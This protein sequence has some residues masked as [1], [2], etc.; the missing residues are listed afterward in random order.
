MEGSSA[1]APWILAVLALVVV[2]ARGISV[3]VP[4][5]G[6]S[7][8]WTVIP[9]KDIA[10]NS[11]TLYRAVTN[12]GEVQQLPPCNTTALRAICESTP[13]CLA[14]NT[15]GYLKSTASTA[16]MVDA[17][18][19]TWV[20]AGG[21]PP[22]T[23]IHLPYEIPPQKDLHY[24]EGLRNASAQGPPSL[25]ALLQDGQAPIATWA[26]LQW[27]GSTINASVEQMVFDRWQFR[28]LAP[29]TLLSPDAPLV[30]VLEYQTD[31]WGYLAFV[32]SDPSQALVLRQTVG[33]LSDIQ[34]AVYTM[35]EMYYDLLSG[36]LTDLVATDILAKT[37]EP[38]SEEL[39]KYMTPTPDYGL[40]GTVKSTMKWTT[41]IVG[42]IKRADD[43][44][45]EFPANLSFP[46]PGSVVFDPLTHLKSRPQNYSVVKNGLFGGYY[47]V[48]MTSARNPNT[49][50]GFEQVAFAAD[51]ADRS[52]Q[53]FIRLYDMETDA[54]TYYQQ[55]GNV[56]DAPQPIPAS[57]F[58]QYLLVYHASLQATLATK[59][60]MAV[61]LPSTEL[62]QMDMAMGALVEGLTVFL[63]LLPNYGTGF[64]YWSVRV[65][66]GS[67]LPLT[68]F[69]VDNA[70]SEWGFPAL[71]EARVQYYMQTFVRPDGTIN[72]Y[73]WSQP[74]CPMPESPTGQFNDG[75]ADY[76]RLLDLY[77]TTA[78]LSQNMDWAKTNLPNITHVADY[79]L[80]LQNTTSNVTDP[81]DWRFGLI[82]GSAEHD[83]CQDQDFYVD[84]QAWSWRG[85]LE[86][87]NFLNQTGL[88]DGQPYLAAAHLMQ[89]KLFA[90]LPNV[91]VFDEQ[92]KPVFVS[93]KLLNTDQPYRS[94]VESREAEYAN[95]RYWPETV[96]AGA[97]PD[98]YDE[99]MLAYRDTHMGI[100]S[101]MS[102]WSD[103]LDDM[104]SLGY[105]YGH[106][107]YNRLPEFHMLHYGHMAN[108]MSPGV[109]SS[110][111]QLSIYGA[112]RF[113][114]YVT[115]EVGSERD[116]DFCVVSASLPA[117]FTKWQ[118]VFAPRD[119]NQ[120]EL[121]K[122]APQRWY[123]AG[124][125][126]VSAAR[127][128]WGV[129]SFSVEA[130]HD[131]TQLQLTFEPS[132]LVNQKCP[133][134]VASAKLLSDLG[135]WQTVVV[136]GPMVV[137]DTDTTLGTATLEFTTCANAINA[138]V[139]FKPT[140]GA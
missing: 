131:A 12:C 19:D 86:F 17:K 54:T 126:G 118:L 65:D 10:N 78:L 49:P 59:R 71:A 18:S 93:A 25:P 27:K 37:S 117:F 7:A 115:P 2:V 108:Y 138:T 43:Y 66:R 134:I 55:S 114:T 53:L 46:S 48:V 45:M 89:T 16:H 6:G 72:L 38:T 121:A 107:R 124:S 62:R 119:L 60:P 57:L 4:K 139:Y 104:P 132:T 99:A 20:M 34:Q 94:M 21:K 68:S 28:G 64:D 22:V 140:R 61:T 77:T 8:A 13:E 50:Q 83:T 130:T 105:G 75:L 128:R 82:Y 85:L 116:L 63:D 11:Y 113:R 106:L 44:L 79:I 125:F 102:R 91:T 95:F 23:P 29:G 33:R 52:T 9:H 24:S 73:N 101:G 15:N 42:R 14:F 58:Y 87:G 122:A 92:G 111:E 88:G 76:G 47:R 80:R 67:G 69:A 127:T 90:R 100:I 1:R 51:L 103:H 137:T 26:R 32:T 81:S 112:D 135:A 109:F 31:Q 97:L 70:L 74:P 35:D 5:S 30:A 110:T 96:L 56:S 41:A 129:I 133:S 36:S 40:L 123:D 39:L 120:V 3:Q 136:D 98:G 84:V